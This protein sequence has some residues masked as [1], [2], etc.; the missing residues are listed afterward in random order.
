MDTFQ[1]TPLFTLVMSC[2]IVVSALGENPR[3]LTTRTALVASVVDK[4]VKGGPRPGSSLKEKAEIESITED[5]VLEARKTSD[6][7]KKKAIIDYVYCVEA[8]RILVGS[9][10]ARPRSHNYALLEYL[11]ERFSENPCPANSAS[12]ALTFLFELEH[13]DKHGVAIRSGLLSLKRKNLLYPSDILLYGL[14][15]ST[16]PKE[17]RA[18]ADGITPTRDSTVAAKGTP[19]AVDALLARFGDKAA[20]GRLLD[21]AREFGTEDTRE[22]ASDYDLTVCLSSVQSMEMKVF[23]AQGLRSEEMLVYAGRSCSPKRFLYGNALA[24]MMTD[25][26][27]FKVAAG[28]RD[29]TESELDEMERWCTQNLGVEYPKT[30][31]KRLHSIAAIIN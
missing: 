26:P 3:D 28:F 7:K 31:R 21:V 17:A 4:L 22:R 13:L 15:P 9:T 2:A 20:L 18:F 10:K 11:V 27:G 12:S 8:D 19:L 23:L 6:E 25:D 29:F 16:T 5:L 30:P 24:K 14:L 1:K